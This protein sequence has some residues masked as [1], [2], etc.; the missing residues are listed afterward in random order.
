MAIQIKNNVNV[1]AETDINAM[2]VVPNNAVHSDCAFTE[3]N[4]DKAGISSDKTSLCGLALFGDIK[5]GVRPFYIL[6]SNFFQKMPNNEKLE[7]QGTTVSASHI[8]S[9]RGYKRRFITE[10]RHKNVAYAYL[11]SK[12]LFRD[13]SRFACE[14]PAD[15]HAHALALYHFITSDFQD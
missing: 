7:K 4:R 11:L 8:G 9:P 5:R 13:F 2:F 15:E 3:F 1:L 10:Q 6:T 14:H 12:N